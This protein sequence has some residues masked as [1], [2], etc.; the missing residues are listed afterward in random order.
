MHSSYNERKSV[1]AERFSRTLKNKIYK[2]MNSIS[3]NVYNAKLDD[4]AN[5]YNHTYYGT[6]KMKAVDVKLCTYFDYRVKNDGK[7]PKFKVFD[8]VRISLYKIIFAKGCI[9]N[10]FFLIAIKKAKNTV[11]ST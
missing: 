9:P 4:I 8:H 10:C 2:F 7:D 6:I 1:V 3:K 5:K 11:P